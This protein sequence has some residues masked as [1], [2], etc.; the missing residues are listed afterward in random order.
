MESI[1]V[2]NADSGFFNIIK[3]RARSQKIVKDEQIIDEKKKANYSSYLDYTLVTVTSVYDYYANVPIGK[4]TI[5]QEH[6][7][8]RRNR[9]KQE[10]KKEAESQGQI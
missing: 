1:L 9:K 4:D 2:Y 3:E 7:K 6:E 10:N 8:I 5:W